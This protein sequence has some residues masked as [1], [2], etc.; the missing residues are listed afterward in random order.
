MVQLQANLFLL[1]DT[2]SFSATSSG[3]CVLATHTDTPVVT[4]PSVS[5]NLLQPLQVLAQL[6]VEE[7]RHHLAGLA[8]LAV[9]LP[10][11][12]VVRDLVLA[13]IL[14]DGDELLHLLLAQLSCLLEDN[15]G[16]PAATALDRGHRKHD[17]CF[18]LNVGVH[19]TKNVLEISRSN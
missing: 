18:P 14:H 17:I 5:A 12:E 13:W 7:V 9:L 8:I 15:V 16:V 11:E 4:Q 6:V 1:G 3:L 10:V 2:D 19:D